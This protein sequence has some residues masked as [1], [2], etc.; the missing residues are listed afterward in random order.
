MV[1]EASHDLLV[2][3]DS[4]IRVTGDM[5]RVVGAEFAADANLALLTCPYRAVPG[6]S[7]WSRLEAVMMNTEFLAGILTARLLEGMKFA[8]GPTIVCRRAAVEAI[9]GFASLGEYLAEDFVFGER[10][11]A[12]GMGVELSRYVVEHRIGSSDFAENKDHRLRWVRSTRRSRPGGYVGQLFTY[13]VPLALLLL[14]VAPWAWPL[15]LVAVGL[16]I[17]NAWQVSQQILADPLT[18][19]HSLLVPVQDV[20]S[21]LY[22]IAGFVGNTIHWRGKEYDLYA[23]GRFAEKRR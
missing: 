13:P 4:D 11:A 23:D 22:W 6:A 18:R 14:V 10:V 8:V 12:L 21:F 7:V 2:M 9:G 20:V 19:H 1:G 15:A 17:A 3:S 5:L 16:R